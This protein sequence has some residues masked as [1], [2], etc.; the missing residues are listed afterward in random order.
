MTSDR[1]VGA[2]VSAALLMTTSVSTASAASETGGGLDRGAL[3]GNLDGVHA[4]GMY[5]AFSSTR[6]TCPAAV[7]GATTGRFSVPGRTRCRVST[8]S[9]SSPWAGT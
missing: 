4:A 5:G 3:R 2:A 7:S 9:A 6:S 1:I 8:A